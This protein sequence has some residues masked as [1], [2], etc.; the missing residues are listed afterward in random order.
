MQTQNLLHP[1]P[2]L[3][4]KTA[5]VRLHSCPYIILCTPTITGN[6]LVGLV[7]VIN[8]VFFVRVCLHVFDVLLS[9]CMHGVLYKPNMVYAIVCVSYYHPMLSSCAV[10]IKFANLRVPS[11]V[12]R[13]LFS[14]VR[15]QFHNFVRQNLRISPTNRGQIP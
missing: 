7:Q 14:V 12:F 5:E 11:V 15:L 3:F 9:R 8:S 4:R 1:G 6:M 2:C 10:F 13:N